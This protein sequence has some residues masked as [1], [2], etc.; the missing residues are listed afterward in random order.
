MF[1]HKVE[2][3]FNGRGS[4]HKTLFG[5]I[6]SVIVTLLLLSYLGINLKKLILFED[7]N[8]NQSVKGQQ[9]GALGE[10]YYSSTKFNEFAFFLTQSL[11]IPV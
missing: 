4:I 7:D 11:N 6:C 1:G 2:L 10:I 3:G 8:I 5:G 9:I